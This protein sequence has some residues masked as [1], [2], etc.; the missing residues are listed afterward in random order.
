LSYLDFNIVSDFDIRISSLGLIIST[1]S[2][3]RIYKLFMQ[4]KANFRN[5]KMNITLDEASVYMILSRSPGQKNKPNSNPIKPKT[6]PIKANSN[7]KQ[8]Q[9]N[10][11]CRKAKNEEIITDGTFS[12]NIK[13]HAGL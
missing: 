1:N 4:N 2:Y 5:D 9:S 8:T 7:P 12:A 3:V 11:I 13:H 10:P 6:N